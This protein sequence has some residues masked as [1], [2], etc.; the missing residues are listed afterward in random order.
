MCVICI[1]KAN[2]LPT[3]R[4]MK[5]MYNANPH[6]M[7]FCSKSTF[8][9]TM[10]FDEFY[11]EIQKVPKGEEVIMHFRLATHGSKRV[12]NCHP[13]KSHGW[14]FAHNGV[15]TG[16]DIEGDRTDSETA[17]DMLIEPIL[18]YG[19]DNLYVRNAINELRGGSRFA[20]LSPEG[21]VYTFGS[22]IEMGGRQYSNVRFMPLSYMCRKAR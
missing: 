9:K 8:F 12:E 18:D 14:C 6:G 1:C 15:I 4:E 10:D 17:F 3:K 21:K 5:M 20:F 7:G 13:F 19:I 11:K 2:N 22:F 16:L